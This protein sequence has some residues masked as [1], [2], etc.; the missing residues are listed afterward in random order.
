M[1]LRSR[2]S[3]ALGQPQ[4]IAPCAQCGNML[5]APEWSEYLDDCRI[6]YLWCCSSCDYQFE[7]LVCYPAPEAR[8]D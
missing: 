1:Q 2:N 3:H 6:R 4:P 7:T 8:P 5:L